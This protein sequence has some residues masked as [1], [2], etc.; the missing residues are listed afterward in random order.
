M[1]LDTMAPATTSQGTHLAGAGTDDS[2]FTNPE[3][4]QFQQSAQIIIAGW[5]P[6]PSDVES[7]RW[8]DGAT[9]TAD[10][11]ERR[12]ITAPTP[13]VKV[14]GATTFF[15]PVAIRT[16]AA[17]PPVDPY[18]PRDKNEHD[19]YV[20]MASLSNNLRLKPTHTYTASVWWLATL[21][22]WS[23]AIVVALV[24]GLGPFYS[25]FLQLFTALIVLFISA[26]ITIHDRKVLLADNHPTAAST[27]WFLLSPLAYLIAR[28]VHVH[29]SMGRGWAPVVMYLICSVVPAAAVISITFL[30]TLAVN[31]LR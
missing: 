28:G 22:V 24:V 1:S 6:D 2:D 8:W 11:K 3:F 17:L 30:M 18:R 5:Y 29:R 15:P 21:P 4:G 7:L 12:P 20:P 10:V 19:T 27:L 9:W 31:L 26:A 16:E 23:T 25:G 13:V 14:T